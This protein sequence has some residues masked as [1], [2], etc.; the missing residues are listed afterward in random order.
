[1]KAIVRTLLQTTWHTSR[2]GLAIGVT[3]CALSALPVL[4]ILVAA[5]VGIVFM[6][7][8][9]FVMLGGL[10]VSGSDFP[11][12]TLL[13]AA[14]AL[15]GVVAIPVAAL[16]AVILAIAAAILFIGL[17]IFPVSLLVEIVLRH[18]RIR[19]PLAQMA[20]FIIAGGLAGL[21]IGALGGWVAFLLQADWQTIGITSGALFLLC[22]VS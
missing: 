9:A 11:M 7:L 6:L 19:S 17:C 14:I 20:G 15:L 1:M 16:V 22:S 3:A 2:Y 8:L 10:A 4:V 12:G 18:A 21:A 5:I 13:V